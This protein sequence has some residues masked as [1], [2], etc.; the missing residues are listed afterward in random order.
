MKKTLLILLFI[1]LVS[2]SDATIPYADIYNSG[3][4]KIYLDNSNIKEFDLE[5]YYGNYI[6]T[7]QFDYESKIVEFD[8]LFFK[9]NKSGIDKYANKIIEKNAIG[10]SLNRKLIINI[11]KAENEISILLKQADDL[12]GFTVFERYEF[13]KKANKLKDFISKKKLEKEAAQLRLFAENN[14]ISVYPSKN[15]KITIK[16]DNK[17]L[18]SYTTEIEEAIFPSKIRSSNNELALKNWYVFDYARNGI[19]NNQYIINPL[20][21]STYVID[22]IEYG[23]GI[24]FE[25]NYKSKKISKTFNKVNVIDWW[26][27]NPPDSLLISEMQ[28]MIGLKTFSIKKAK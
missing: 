27:G 12:D 6:D 22:T 26:F 16:K 10:D 18:E 19:V 23:N 20:S 14:F 2:C 25:D 11:E 3:E 21:L 5:M 13:V 7:I 15:V 1:P 17:V 24:R 8:T 28:S 4:I 9:I